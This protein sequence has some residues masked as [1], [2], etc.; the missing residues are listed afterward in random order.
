MPS[1]NIQITRGATRDQKSRPVADATTSLVETPGKAPEHIHVVIQEI[2][3][4]DRGFAGR[5]TDDWRAG[6]PR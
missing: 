3:E 4:E 5:L 2:A 6:R 1:V